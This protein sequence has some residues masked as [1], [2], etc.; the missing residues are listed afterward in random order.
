ME[1]GTTNFGRFGLIADGKSSTAIF[2]ATAN[3]AAAADDV[4][5]AVNA[6]TADP[7]WFGGATRPAINMLVKIGSDIY[8]ILT[9][10]P[11]GTGWN[12]TISRPDPTDRS[13][14]LGLIN[15]HSD[16]DPVEFYLRSM[17]STASH[18]FEYAGS[19]TNY[20]ALPE[21]GGVPV[22]L[23]E[24]VNVNDG[25]VWLTSTDQSG[26][27]KVGDTFQ[28]DQQTG[29][30][31]IDPSSV[32][33][34]LVSDNSPQLGGDL[35]VLTR[36]ITTS[37]GNTGVVIE[38]NGN[39]PVTLKSGAA[40]R[41]VVSP[42]QLTA[43]FLGTAAAPAYSFIADPDTGL[44]SPGANELALSTGG[45]ARL[46]IDASGNVA[47]P[48]GLS[49][50][51]NN[52]LTTAGGAVTGDVTL[53]AQSDLRFADADSSNWV[54]FQGP[55]T[56]S[57]NV[58]WTLPAADGTTGQ[59]LSTNGSGALSWATASGGGGGGASV[60]TS[61]TAPTSPADGDLWY[62]SVG[63]RLYVYYEDPNTSQWV[64]AAPQGGGDAGFSKLEVGNTKAEV[65]DTGSN[66]T[67]TV[68]TE[69]T[70]R[71]TVG[72]TGNVS[73]A[74]GNLV[75]STSGTGIDFSAT[76]NSSGTMTSELLSDYEEGTWTPVAGRLTGGNI[77]ATYNQQVGRYTKIGRQ[78]I[79]ECTIELA[80]VTSQGSSA[81][82]ITGLPFTGANAYQ[83]TGAVYRNNAATTSVI[84]SVSVHGGDNAIYFHENINTLGLADFAWKAG[85]MTFSLTYTV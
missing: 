57:S 55:A 21:N 30:V 59:V 31:T 69:G 49:Q 25:R 35:D 84:A 43:G 18:T 70:S 1:V 14:N 10:S 58:T 22:E 47:V 79:L 28:V 78:V 29:Y 13:I 68:T 71:F 40:D 72:S 80:S 46:T 73:I 53:N 16:T 65:T 15:G 83:G 6:P 50:G 63:G 76:A 64:D 44:L 33:I 45:T 34:N 82:T 11:N 17:V 85:Y 62:D 51:G 42:T 24:A 38:G 23:N 77:T 66:G 75:F 26:K 12:V 20:S 4:T 67:F 39:G 19:G 36:R 7:S 52:V 41:F 60:T 54:A 32:S 5:F 56:V 37:E 27:F 2:T 8:P 3:G 81:A 9:A 61:D 48:G 74:N